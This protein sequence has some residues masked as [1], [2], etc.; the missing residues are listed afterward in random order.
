MKTFAK[1]TTGQSLIEFALLIPML[2]LLLVGIMEFSRAWM[3]RNILT[4]A[5]REAVRMYAVQNNTAAANARAD[6]VLSSGGLDLGRRTI[7]HSN[8]GGAVNYTIR[9]DFPV[10]MPGL[11]PRLMAMLHG[12]GSLPGWSANSFPL[13]STT[14]MRREW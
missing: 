7:V 4:G 9:Y 1:Q 3:T 12:T 11:L 2:L 5:A 10:S 8:S 14:T 13:S 6:Q